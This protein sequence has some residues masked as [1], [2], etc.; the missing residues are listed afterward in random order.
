MSLL[1]ALAGFQVFSKAEAQVVPRIVYS[2]ETCIVNGGLE[3]WDL[4]GVL[5]RNDVASGTYLLAVDGATNTSVMYA[6]TSVS[7]PDDWLKPYRE[8]PYGRYLIMRK[9][10]NPYPELSAKM[11]QFYQAYPAGWTKEFTPS[12]SQI[13]FANGAVTQSAQ[14]PIASL[15]FPDAS[16]TVWE[17]TQSGQVQNA[18]LNWAN[19]Q[20]TGQIAVVQGYM[21][22]MAQAVLTSG[23][24]G[25]TPTVVI[26]M[27]FSDGSTLKLEANTTS[28]NGQFQVSR[29]YGA[30]RD[31]HNNNVPMNSAQLGGEQVG[32]IA[33]YNFS[34]DD[35]NKFLGR[36]QLWGVEIVGNSGP[37]LACTSTRDSKGLLYTHCVFQ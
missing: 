25:S 18:V 9:V 26:T 28:A 21:H 2:C 19:S 35:L 34:Q 36:A 22:D 37:T 5:F 8:L 17:A 23:T 4:E 32:D 13:M 33:Y 29:Q 12:A 30:A 27:R 31:K 15:T 20:M 14:A 10:Q 6:A 11:L 3:D 1:F 7:Q 16:V 24:F